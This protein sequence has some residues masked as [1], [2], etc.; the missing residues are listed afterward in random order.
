M[1]LALSTKGQQCIQGC[2]NSRQATGSVEE[3]NLGTYQGK[4]LWYRLICGLCCPPKGGCTSSFCSGGSTGCF[5]R[6]SGHLSNG[7][8]TQ[9]IAAESRAQIDDT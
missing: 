2:N 5:C 3:T 4:P 1:S 6:K 7:T 9:H 8:D